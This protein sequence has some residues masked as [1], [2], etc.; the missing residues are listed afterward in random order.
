MPILAIGLVAL[1]VFLSMFF[2]FLSA[3]LAERRKHEEMEREKAA[4]LKTNVQTS[5]Q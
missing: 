2:M 3:M 4:A 5:G 1:L